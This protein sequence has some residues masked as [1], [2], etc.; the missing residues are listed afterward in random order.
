MFAEQEVK[1]Y[2]DDSDGKTTLDKIKIKK[3][4]NTVLTITSN[5]GVVLTN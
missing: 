5:G 1:R 3:D 4:G 2:A